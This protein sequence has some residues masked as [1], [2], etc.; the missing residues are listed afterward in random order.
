MTQLSAVARE[1]FE[2]AGIGVG[3]FADARW[4]SRDWRG[5]VCGCT[6]DRCVGFHHEGDEDCG[7][8]PVLIQEHL[9]ALAAA[10][11]AIELWARYVVAQGEDID[12]VREDVADWV[13]RF[14]R[15]AP[16]W[17]LDELVDGRPGISITSRYNDQHHLVWAAPSS[18]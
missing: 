14:H 8:R 12:A 17:S 11:Q 2:A 18:L 16:S 6:D 9:D 15:G 1:E 5:D 3:D 10:E 4:G 7:C 13:G